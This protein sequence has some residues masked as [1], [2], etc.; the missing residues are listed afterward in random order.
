MFRYITDCR[1]KACE[2]HCTDP[3]LWDCEHVKHWLRW[4]VGMFSL[5]NV[6]VD[7]VSWD[8]PQLMLLQYNDFADYIPDDP[9]NVFWTHL[10]L[11]RKYKF[12]G[13]HVTVNIVYRHYGCYVHIVYRNVDLCLCW[14]VCVVLN[15]LSYGIDQLHENHSDPQTYTL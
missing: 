1:Y 3:E 14:S 13:E 4:A 15:I 11:L 6:D 2:V 5:R 7:S 8:G 12:V 10:E 9:K